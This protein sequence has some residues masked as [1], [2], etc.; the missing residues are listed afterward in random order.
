MREID[1]IDR[2][3]LAAVQRDST[4]TVSALAEAANTSVATVQRRLARLKADGVVQRE[5][6]ILDRKKLG[7]GMT[8]I[9]MVELERE[10]VDQIDAFARRANAEPQVQQCYYVTGE[11]DFCL[12]CTASD[13]DDFESL[14]R[15]I[16]FDEPNVR[17]FR[18]SV[19]MG[20]RKATLEIPVSAPPLATVHDG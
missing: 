16:L 17:K 15:R 3:I 9:V 13:M 4:I 12:I 19:V 6:A 11:A 18:T 10:R 20:V 5:V 8:F 7:Q 2:A 14:T 1:Q